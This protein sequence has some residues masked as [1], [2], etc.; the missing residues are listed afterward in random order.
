MQLRHRTSEAPRTETLTRL[1][2]GGVSAD[3]VSTTTAPNDSEPNPFAFTAR[4]GVTPAILVYSN[5]VTMNGTS[6][7]APVSVEAGE[8]RLYRDSAWSNWTS[9]AGNTN[10]GDRLQLRH[11]SHSGQGQEVVTTVTVGGY[12]ASFSSTTAD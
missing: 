12:S 7:A 6:I 5:T 10:P 11:R 9:E 1:T 3:F 2:I 4:T 8:Y